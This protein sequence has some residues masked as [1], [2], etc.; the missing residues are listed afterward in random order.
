[1][2]WLARGA[3]AVLLEGAVLPAVAVR[4][5]VV[6]VEDQEVAGEG[7]AG[8]DGREVEGKEAPA[9]APGEE[10]TARGVEVAE[11]Q[12]EGF[13]FAEPDGKPLLSRHE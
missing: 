8:A 6:E 11:V 1:M 7:G 3:K 5:R 12:E 2:D 4:A 9:A 10:A 13:P